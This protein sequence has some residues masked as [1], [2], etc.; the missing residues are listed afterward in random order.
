MFFYMRQ[1]N[2]ARYLKRKATF[3]PFCLLKA[4]FLLPRKGQ[5]MDRV[6][7]LRPSSGAPSQTWRRSTS[8]VPNSSMCSSKR[9][10]KT[11]GNEYIIYG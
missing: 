11:V 10:R 3:K 5:I 2:H 1:V 6:I 8:C 9:G 7:G 4:L